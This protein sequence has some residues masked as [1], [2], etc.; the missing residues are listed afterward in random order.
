MGVSFQ[1]VKRPAPVRSRERSRHE[2][3]GSVSSFMNE[4]QFLSAISRERRRSERSRDPFVLML[5]ALDAV[6][7]NGTRAKKIQAIVDCLCSSTRETDVSGW[8]KQ[9][10]V[11]GIIFTE[12]GDAKKEDILLSL[13][14]RI[15]ETISAT[16]EP[17]DA[18][19][20][21]L[22]FYFFPDEMGNPLDSVEMILYP[23]FSGRR[24]PKPVMQTLKRAFDIF[25]SASG[26]IILSPLLLTIAALVKLTSDGPALFKQA[27]VGQ[28]GRRFNFLKFR[29]MYANNDPA[30]HKEYV[31]KFIAGQAELRKD[32][33]NA[34]GVFKLINDPR[35]TPLGRFLRK[36]SLDELPQLVNVLRGEMSLIGPR[37]PVPY[38]FESYDI[39]HRR[40][41][42]EVK[43]GI[44][45]LW[46]VNGRS[47]TSFDEMVRLDLR[48]AKDWSFWLDMKILLQ[49]PA[50]VFSGD[51]AY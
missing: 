15:G 2:E 13:R 32:P 43:P 4:T 1:L 8:Y 12:L 31:Q 42:V 19:A 30:K 37:P 40:R 3:A 6:G 7:G 5:A 27:R 29:S 24:Q 49:T 20:I 50:A 16:V 28:F 44:T 23:D 9:S 39:W 11:V 51:G 22:A 33:K 17:E 14:S 25:A 46:Q 45:G 34:T 21:N 48:Y 41:V 36:T 26:L 18:A 10:S 35:I 38:E 47:R